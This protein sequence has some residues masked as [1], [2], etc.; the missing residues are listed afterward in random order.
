M[1]DSLN[2]LWGKL[3]VNPET[4]FWQ[5]EIHSM[6]NNQ[7]NAQHYR[8]ILANKMTV[9][10]GFFSLAL[11]A[12]HP[13]VVQAGEA[14]VFKGGTV[15]TVDDEFSVSEAFAVQGNKI[16]A[17]GPE[18][19][20]LSAAGT[21]AN[22]VDLN[23]KVVL[24]GFVEA[25]AHLISGAM[26]ATT[27]ADLRV[28]RFET[29][30]EVL[31]ELKRIAE[32]TPPGE[33]VMGS[34]FDP[35]LQVGPS[36]L[37]FDLLDKV[38]T[39]HPVFVLN[40]SGHLAYANR[41][42]FQKAGITEDVQN[43][44]G[45]EYSRDASNKLNG[46]MK[47]NTAFLPVLNANPAVA[48]AKPADA[49]IQLGKRF[50]Q[51][52]LTTVAELAFGTISEGP[53][54]IE[55]LKQLSNSDELSIRIRAYP[56]S[57]YEAGWARAGVIDNPGAG[58]ERVRLCGYKLIAD[59]SNQGFTGLQRE[60]YLNSNNRGLAYTKVDDLVALGTKW[61]KKGWLLAIHGNGDAAIDNILTACEKMKS[62]GVDLERVR[63]RIEHCSILH[64]EQ[65]A[66]MKELGISASFLIGHVHFWGIAMRDEVFGEEKA[67]KLDRCRSVEE[68]GIRY[69]LHSDYFVT[70][71]D[72]LHMIEMAVTRTTWKEPDYVLAPEEC[73]SVE[74]A[75]RA[76][77]AEAA[78]MMGSELE[79]GS[80]ETGKLADFVILDADPRKVAKD[81]IKNIRVLETWMDGIQVY[82]ADS[83]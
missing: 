11:F 42:A 63:T 41:L 44:P 43:P 4:T 58:N 24:P 1:V 9:I 3:A 36:E 31:A 71:P 66:K 82:K 18:A 76:V 2:A 39:K 13:L 33:W 37:T 79:V 46:V 29:T 20:V 16:L 75:I 19:D 25:H 59:G 52:G 64:D 62:A 12:S 45:A 55:I 49:V 7:P 70:E 28:S 80:I 22:V 57:N 10:V 26:L 65:I 54:E 67:R 60:P 73:V 77:T 61:A 14:T 74:S 68:A 51:V 27:S 23:G 53:G 21:N 72:P 78:W 50:N 30:E 48:N 17:V 40:A 5:S 69:T 81:Q 32:N 38:S 56:L 6:S 47:N 8:R 34:N 83:N 35:T 15:L